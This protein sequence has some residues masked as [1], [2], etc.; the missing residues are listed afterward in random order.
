VVVDAVPLCIDLMQLG[1]GRAT[2]EEP[3]KHVHRLSSGFAYNLILRYRLPSQSSEGRTIT[4]QRTST[5]PASRMMTRGRS[6][7]PRASWRRT[8]LR[9]HRGNRDFLCR[10][11]GPRQRT[12]CAS[13]VKPQRQAFRSVRARIPNALLPGCRLKTNCVAVVWTSAEERQALKR[14]ALESQVSVAQL[15]EAL[16]FGPH[17]SLRTAHSGKKACR[18]WKKFRRFFRLPRGFQRRQLDSEGCDGFAGEGRATEA[19][20][21]SNNSVDG[22]LRPAGPVER[23]HNPSRCRNSTASLTA[24]TRTLTSSP[25]RTS[26]YLRQHAASF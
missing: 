8:R 23:R 14:M 4:D 26:R 22:T 17:H 10:G 16:A 3:L 19:V 13:S 24:G 12:A 6:R 20:D 1:P 15:I 11:A 2:I 7:G 5:A 25:R 9:P 21:G 18:S